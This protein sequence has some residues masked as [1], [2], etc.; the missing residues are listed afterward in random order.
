MKKASKETG[1]KQIAIAGGVSANS[2][3]QNTL[4]EGTKIYG[5][6]VY[7]PRLGYSLDNAGMVAVTGYYKFLQ[8]DFIGQDAIPYARMVLN[9]D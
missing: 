7:I 2:G 6:Q 3:L 4:R 1:I 8:N 5:W 9:E